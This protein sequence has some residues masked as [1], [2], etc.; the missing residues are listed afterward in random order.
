MGTKSS[1]NL[2][3][4]LILGGVESWRGTEVCGSSPR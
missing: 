2:Y 4:F 1:Y 3:F